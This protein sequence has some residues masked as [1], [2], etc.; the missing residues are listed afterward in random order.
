MNGKLYTANELA[1]MKGVQVAAVWRM[2]R[3][4]RI[5]PVRSAQGTPTNLFDEATKEK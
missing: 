1:E 5:K 2:I 3:K 4:G